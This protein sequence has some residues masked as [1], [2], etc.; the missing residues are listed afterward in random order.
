MHSSRIRIPFLAVINLTTR[1]NQYKVVEENRHIG[2]GPEWN[3]CKTNYYIENR[4]YRLD[5]VQRDQEIPSSPS[6]SF[7][8][9]FITFFSMIAVLLGVVLLFHLPPIEPA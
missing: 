8:F 9:Y 6:L 4:D 2:N 5:V 3:P 1:Y 7:H